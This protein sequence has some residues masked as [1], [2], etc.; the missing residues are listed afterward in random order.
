MANALLGA[1]QMRCTSS[2]GYARAV[3]R[4]V[5]PKSFTGKPSVHASTQG[6]VRTSSITKGNVVKVFLTLSE[7]GTGRVMMVSVSY[8]TSP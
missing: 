8:Y 6:A 1:L 3:Y 2:N 5:L 7:E 4:F